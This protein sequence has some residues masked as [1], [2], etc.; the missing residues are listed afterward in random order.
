MCIS[1]GHATTRLAPTA[2]TARTCRVFSRFFSL[3]GLD[4]LFSTFIVHNPFFFAFLFISTAGRLDHL[5]FLAQPAGGAFSQIFISLSR[6]FHCPEI[7]YPTSMPFLILFCPFHFSYYFQQVIYL[8]I[9]NLNIQT[10]T[11]VAIQHKTSKDSQLNA[12]NI[13]QNTINQIL[14]D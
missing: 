13:E 8:N 1:A 10:K 9:F 11:S 2:I 14:K 6:M 5:I 3:T 12:K 4:T 7:T